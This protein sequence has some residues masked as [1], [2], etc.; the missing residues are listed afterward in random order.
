MVLK[1]LRRHISGYLLQKLDVPQAA[2]LAGLVRSPENYNPFNDTEKAK[3]RRNL[4]LKLMYEQGFIDKDVYTESLSAPVNLNN[5]PDFSGIAEE[6]RFAPYFIDFVKQ[7]LYDKKFSDYDV[8][9]GGLRIYTTLDM[10]LQNKAEDAINKVFPEDPGPS[11]SL[12]SVDPKNG[13]IYA[14]IGGKD[15]SQSKFNIVTQGQRQP[16]S[17]FKVPVLM[18]SIRQ[19]MSPNDKYNPNGP[20]VIDMPSGPDWK[21]ENYGGKTYEQMK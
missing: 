12:I 7:Q 3:S 21:V 4:V 1:K 5:N 15:Y 17:V 18:E 9:K 16:G 13:Y 11:Y 14:L 19:H 6:N 10:N 8:F 20:I 2:L